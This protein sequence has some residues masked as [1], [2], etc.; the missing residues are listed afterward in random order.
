M[1]QEKK[2]AEVCQIT[3]ELDRLSVTTFRVT[4]VGVHSHL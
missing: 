1:K 2:K 3:P 4:K